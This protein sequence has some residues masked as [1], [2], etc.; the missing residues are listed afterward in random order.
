MWFLRVCHQVPH[1]LYQQIG[2]AM[3]LQVKFLYSKH[4]VIKTYGL[5][6]VTVHEFF[7]L[8]DFAC[9]E[10]CHSTRGIEMRKKDVR[11]E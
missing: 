7:A 6:G 2:V 5:V 10:T 3:E 8:A 11:R 4:H 9:R 1:E